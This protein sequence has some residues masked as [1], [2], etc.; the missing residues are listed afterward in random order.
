MQ[1]NKILLG[2]LAGGI[3]LFLLGWI[4]YG[5]LL[6][7]FAATNYNQCMNRP[8]MDMIWWALIL[9]NLA[10][11][12]L[13]AFIFSRTGTTGFVGGAKLGAI[14]GIFLSLSIDL[15]YYSMTTMYVRPSAIL[16]DVAAYII[17]I[18]LAGAVVAWVMGLVKK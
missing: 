9:S 7:D 3:A 18:A 10:F 6:M 16:V 2:G 1:T 15:G 5:I 4:I 14:I 11:G 17:Y 12:F 13:L 8:N